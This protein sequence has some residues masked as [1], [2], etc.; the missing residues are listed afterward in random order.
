LRLAQGLTVLG[1]ALAAGPVAVITAYVFTMGVHG[2]AN[3]VHEAMVHRAVTDP[4]KRATVVSANS[5]TAQTGGMLGGIALGALA[6][7]AG[8]ATGIVVGAAILAAPAPLY[9]LAGR[10]PPP[11]DPPPG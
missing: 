5:M 3:P 11:A 1:I 7:A 4:G 2:A 8:L 9:L 10:Q 6:D